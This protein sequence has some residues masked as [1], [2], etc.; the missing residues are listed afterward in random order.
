MTKELSFSVSG[1]V[2]DIHWKD[3]KDWLIGDEERE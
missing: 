3:W 2:S 1:I